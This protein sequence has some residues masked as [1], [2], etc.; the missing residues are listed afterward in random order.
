MAYN[1][2]K[3]KTT[4]IRYTYRYLDMRIRPINSTEMNIEFTRR[5]LAMRAQLLSQAQIKMHI[6]NDCDFLFSLPA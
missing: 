4:I 1:N 3:K 5:F 6:T 2:N